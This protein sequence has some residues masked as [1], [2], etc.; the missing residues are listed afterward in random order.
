MGLKRPDQLSGVSFVKDEDIFIVQTGVA[1]AQTTE[2]KVVSVKRKDLGLVKSEEFTSYKNLVDATFL[3]RSNG[4]NLYYPKSNPDNFVKNNSSE[5]VNLNIPN[6]YPTSNPSGYVTLTEA[7]PRSNP[8]GFI[9]DS[10][11]YPSSNPSG[12][13]GHKTFIVQEEEDYAFGEYPRVL[14]RGTGIF[15]QSE[16][17]V[18]NN[19]D[20]K[21]IY[22]IRGETYIFNT[23][24]LKGTLTRGFFFANGADSYSSIER[25]IRQPN[26][27]YDK[28]YIENNRNTDGLDIKI[29]IPYDFPSNKLFWS[30]ENF[31]QNP[32]SGCFEI[33]PKIGEE[34][35]GAS[36]DDSHLYPRNNPSGYITV[37]EVP[38]EENLTQIKFFLEGED[39][40]SYLRIDNEQDEIFS[41][42]TYPSGYTTDPN[43]NSLHPI[44][45]NRGQKYKL[46]SISDVGQQALN[47]GFALSTNTGFS[48]EYTQGLTISGQDWSF[49]SAQFVS[50]I[51]RVDAIFN[52]PH[53]APKK[54][55]YGLV[56][57]T[58]QPLIRSTGE[59]VILDASDLSFD[60]SHLYRANNPSGF[61]LNSKTGQLGN[62]ININVTQESL[63]DQYV[64]GR[65]EDYVSNAATGQSLTLH[66]GL[67]YQLHI[68][69]AAD[70]VIKD[71]ISDGY[72]DQFDV[73]VTSNAITDG[74][75]TFK[76]PHD[77]PTK[78]Y[79]Q[80]AGNSSVSGV[81]KIPS[82]D[83]DDI[84]FSS[85]DARYYPADS[86]PSGYLGS[87]DT[88]VFLNQINFHA[89]T[90]PIGWRVNTRS[91]HDNPNIVNPD[92]YL[93]RGERYYLNIA[94][95]SFTNF[96]IKSEPNSTGAVYS[97]D[98]GVT[99]N[100]IDGTEGGTLIFTV[101][102]DSPE[103]LYYVDSDGSATPAV[104]GK[105]NILKE[106][107]SLLP[108]TE[109]LEV[110]SH[111]ISSESGLHNLGSPSKPWGE[112]FLSSGTLHI[113][114][115]SISILE[116]GNRQWTKLSNALIING[117]ISQNGSAPVEF[118]NF[119]TRS[120]TGVFLTSDDDTAYVTNS[121]TGNLVTK[122][123]TGN[124]LTTYQPFDD[125]HLVHKT[126]TGNLVTTNMT[127]SSQVLKFY[128]LDL[129]TGTIKRLKC[130]EEFHY[131]SSIATL[132]IR[133]SND[134]E[135]T[136]G[137]GFDDG[138]EIDGNIC[139]SNGHN[140]IQ[141][142]YLDAH[143]GV[144]TDGTVSGKQGAIFGTGNYNLAE[145][146]DDEI[147]GT[148]ITFCTSNLNFKNLETNLAITGTLGVNSQ[149][150]V[151][152]TQGGGGGDSAGEDFTW[153]MM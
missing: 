74:I 3:T 71:A 11:F 95:G 27:G 141:D 107:S 97:Y 31:S 108:R 39:E 58:N 12:Y 127:G 69:G 76:V 90:G 149:G 66:R 82:A 67:T 30:A 29:K 139:H 43:K 33:Y 86:N 80:S 109:L 50:I 98:V 83:P 104:T 148:G 14:I 70:F 40:D 4:E 35:E 32:A 64:I 92:I 5:V 101:P 113:G 134:P 123:Q 17:E 153:F 54:L 2:R 144:Y 34:A 111:I 106:T 48:P 96:Y 116:S 84:N 130:T 36:F 42:D 143:S 140:V 117:P 38:Q 126:D 28:I 147:E 25:S 132:G 61:T 22:L 128:A 8:S 133:C 120:E 19:Y 68:S 85:F 53:D 73:G 137:G 55:Y 77:A 75:I 88:G 89:G 119:V 56:K 110:R 125:V 1:N 24:K 136:I 47:I 37:N 103:T 59:F 91:H 150:R 44:Y 10:N 49:P 65:A 118:S 46:T 87:A 41:L 142:G 105:I 93:N 135:C 78:L 72:N 131:E 16:D 7:Y 18:S 20:D 102:Y 15:A 6:L 62:I 60:D 81:I 152:V 23:E 26:D 94:P 13:V 21:K 145:F 124:F 115:Q 114:Q 138:I 79:Y 99:G 45:L 151:Y 146:V 129:Q 9:S 112:L 57:N 122:S 121:S 52:V 100:G 51:P 63:I